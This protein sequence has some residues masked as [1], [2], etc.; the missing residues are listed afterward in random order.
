MEQ[1]SVDQSPPKIIVAIQHIVEDSEEHGLM[2][3]FFSFSELINIV[4]TR[5]MVIPF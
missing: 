5:F 1:K 3:S 4:M 2:E